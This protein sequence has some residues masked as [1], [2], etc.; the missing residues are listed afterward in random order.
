[1][2]ARFL[3]L[4]LWTAL[5]APVWP[6]PSRAATILVPTQEATIQDGILAAA[7]GDTVL[8]APG[9]YRGAG[10]RDVSFLGK[11]V[12]V[13][14]AQGSGST[15]VDCEVLGRGFI[16]MDGESSAA[17]L[18]GLTIVN[19]IARF[20][21]GALCIS[22][23]PTIVDCIFRDNV[24]TERG[25]GLCCVW[26]DAALDSCSFMENTAREDIWH[27]EGGGLYGENSNLT[28][29]HC[30]FVDNFVGGT[31]GGLCSRGARVDLHDCLF[32]INGSSDG[33]G[34]GAAFFSTIGYARDCR[35]FGNVAPD[36]GGVVAYGSAPQFWNCRFI[37]NWAQGAAGC[38]GG[39]VY[40]AG[41]L[42][43]HECLFDGNVAS[44][45]D[46]EGTGGA[47]FVGQGGY[48]LIE[49]S[50]LHRNVADRGPYGGGL[51]AGVFVG[52]LATAELRNTI[53]T[54]SRDGEAIHCVTESA[55]HL[56]CCDLYGNE[57]GDWVGCIAG[58]YGTEGN[59]SAGP[60]FCDPENGDFG[61]ADY[62]PCAPDQSPGECGLIGAYGVACATPVAVAEPELSASGK[63]QIWNYPNPF[64]PVTTIVYQ[65]PHPGPVTLRIYDV[66]G[67]AVCNLLDGTTVDEG[68]HSVLWDGTDGAG[69]PV[70]SGIYFGR[71]QVGSE[72]E[73]R[74]LVLI[75]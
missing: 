63:L 34:G 18:R 55:V 14:S 44:D 68:Q 54:A 38:K 32:S 4:L 19:G 1:M 33:Q 30:A 11:D 48:L 71:L 40:G 12:V 66:S 31:G 58:L 13:T 25:G 65:V 59:I 75:K 9:L 50:T 15:T 20:G 22:S 6:T 51:G 47:I 52:G 57:G 29:S 37:S 36:G 67:R 27:G 28:L 17:M 43:F 3:L 8:I 16:L 23:S 73:F 74:R 46:R 56:S 35:F 70:E 41:H 53:I 45:I 2:V 62:S 42:E 39:A 7:E 24:A 72:E 21:A 26:S 10:N 64:N 5:L 61:L 60:F 49:S 69:R